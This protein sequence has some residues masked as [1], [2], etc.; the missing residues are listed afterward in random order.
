M[1]LCASCRVQSWSCTTAL[2][3]H[4]DGRSRSG[5]PETSRRSRRNCPSSGQV[6]G[7]RTSIAPNAGTAAPCW[8]QPPARCVPKQ[9]HCPP[10]DSA[11]YVRPMAKVSPRLVV[12]IFAGTRVAIGVAFALAPDRFSTGS[13]G[14]R[15]D[16][17]MTRSFAVREVVLGV[18]GLAAVASSDRHPSA[19][20]SWAGLGALTDAGDLAAS[21][22]GGSR[23]NHAAR[24]PALVAAMGLAA[25]LWAFA[26]PVQ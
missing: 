21:L 22:A 2:G 24:I 10:P 13:D 26:A 14:T 23:R 18:G 11:G 8:W 5:S 6:R 4:L 7:R 20:R 12:G 9:A 1:S 17:L 25:E 16:T 19:V 3:T 15:S